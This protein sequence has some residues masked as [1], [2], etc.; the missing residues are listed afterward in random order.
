MFHKRYYTIHGI[1]LHI[2]AN[3]F[4]V[5]RQVGFG[6]SISGYGHLVCDSAKLTPKASLRDKPAN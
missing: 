4:L 1:N 5:G 6:F 3:K 2:F